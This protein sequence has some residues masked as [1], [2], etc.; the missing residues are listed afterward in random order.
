MT[1]LNYTRWIKNFLLNK[2]GIPR[3]FSAQIEVTMRCNFRCEFC[4]IWQNRDF[5]RD[6]EMTTE[7]MKYIIDELDR[8]QITNLSF[9]GGEPL[10]RRD[11]GDLIQHAASKGIIIGMATNGWFLKERLATGKLD[12][13]EFMMVSLDSID[14]A[15]HDRGRGVEGAWQ[16][17]VEGI[18]EC[19]KHDIKVIIHNLI[20]ADNIH[21]ME[22]MA[23]LA[24]DLKCMV[25]FLPCEDIV[26]ETEH[27]MYKV[28]DDDINK[29]IP[30]LDL[31]AAR[32]LDLIKKYKNVTSDPLTVKVIQAGG[33]GKKRVGKKLLYRQRLLRC[34]V[35]AATLFVRYNGM[36]NF[37]CKIHPVLSRSALE[38][39]ISKLYNTDEVKQ[40]Q[41]MEDG[42]PFCNGCRLG[43][44][45]INSLIPEWQG[46]W[47]KYIRAFF[48]GN[49]WDQK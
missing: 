10:L 35:A 47:S 11:I 8:T 46:V 49:L 6:P 40:I 37:P 29:F 43:C 18:R 3:P 19:R 27:G 34:H 21:E 17:A 44:G 41:K 22:R 32:T 30:N 1:R 4:G 28:E 9:T 48:R 25:E 26:R 23:Q 38:Y 39:P 42:F 13:V 16:R 24:Q 15:K 33:F 31:Y 45:I 12:P 14:P 36:V 20:T 7:Q 5:Y 2:V